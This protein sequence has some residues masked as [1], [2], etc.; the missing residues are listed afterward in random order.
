MARYLSK[1]DLN[2]FEPGYSASIPLFITA[3]FLMNCMMGSGFI[4]ATGCL[5]PIKYLL[6]SIIIVL[7]FINVEL[8]RILYV[9]LMGSSLSM[10]LRNL[11]N[12]TVDFQ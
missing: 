4:K 10:Q 3:R 8:R 11:L 9:K 6:R 7:I 1:I 2:V 12:R 5:R